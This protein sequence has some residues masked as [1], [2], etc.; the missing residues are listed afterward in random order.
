MLNRC[1]PFVVIGVRDPVDKA[2][3]KLLADIDDAKSEQISSSSPE[4]S[5]GCCMLMLSAVDGD[6][7]DGFGWLEEG[8]VYEKIPNTSSEVTE[9]FRL[10]S[11][12]IAVSSI[13]L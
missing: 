4:S 11:F 2:I 13:V 10:N 8:T 6:K 5:V 3:C 12:F 9:P 1:P 7:I